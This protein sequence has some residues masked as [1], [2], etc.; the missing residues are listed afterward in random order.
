MSLLTVQNVHKE[1]FARDVLAGVTLTVERRERIGLVGENGS[2]KSTMMRLMAGEEAPDQG[3][4]RLSAN[5]VSSY[6]SQHVDDMLEPEDEQLPVLSSPQIERLERELV[7]LADAL[8]SAAEQGLSEAEQA[9]IAS[10][11]HQVQEQFQRLDG[12]SYE[13]RYAQALAG[14]G[15]Q[16][17]ILRQPLGTLSGGEK[18]RVM[19][20]RRLLDNPDLLMLD[21]PTNHLDVAGLEW[22]EE[23]LAQFKGSA[24][25]ISHDRYFLDRVATRICDLRAGQLTSYPGNYSSYVELKAEADRLRA[26]EVERL[27]EEMERQADIVQTAF[28]HRNFSQYHAREKVVQKLRDRLEEAKAAQAP[29]AQRM[30]FRFIPREA[31]SDP[32]RIIIS[33]RDVAMGYGDR[34]LFE[35]VRFELRARDKVVLVGPNGCGKSTLLRILLGQEESFTGDILLSSTIRYAAMDQ[36]VSFTDESLT[37][38]EELMSRTELTEGQARNLLARYGFRAIDVFKQIDVLSG[39]ERS[40][41]YLCCLLEDRPDVLFLDEPTNHLDIPSREILEDALRDF[42]GAILAVSHDRYFIQRCADRVLGFSG[43]TV[44][45]YDNYEQYRRVVRQA[46][47]QAA[48]LAAAEHLASKQAADERVLSSPR[49]SQSSVGVNRARE[50][51]LR[52]RLQRELSELE[53]RISELE[54]EAKNVEST[55]ATADGPDVYEQYADILAE[56]ERLNTRYYEIGEHPLLN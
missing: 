13:A 44:K 52:G 51:Q 25:I 7:R 46:E 40:R 1:Y 11:Y 2:G 49:R 20:A 32:S 43:T 16:G 55:L 39:G 54:A 5:V 26:Q 48:Q 33:A 41:L 53:Q 38:L 24:I 47:E 17:E 56:L 45:P 12:Y 36:Y 50:R 15:L 9:A 34:T 28:E 14:L 27:E 19:L 18:M 4:V 23:Y 42:E 35:E 29:G 3:L 31:T 30:S 8:A 21:E 6:L 22:L 10:E 37:I